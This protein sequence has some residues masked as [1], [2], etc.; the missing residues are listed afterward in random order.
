MAPGPG[1]R[2]AR[3]QA[4]DVLLPHVASQAR[5]LRGREAARQGDLLPHRQRHGL[6]PGR[7]G[8]AR[9]AGPAN[10]RQDRAEAHARRGAL[11]QDQAQEVQLV[12]GRAGQGRPQRPE[13]GLRGGRPHA[14]ARHRR[15]RIQPAVGQGV[16]VTGDGP[17]QQRDSGLVGGR[18]REHGPGRRDDGDARTQARRSGAPAFRPGVAIPA[19]V[20]S[21][22]AR[23][24]RHR[25]EHVAE[26]HLPGQRL[27]GGVL[28]AYEG[29]ILPR[30]EI[31]LVRILQSRARRLHLLLEHAPLSGR[32]K[33][34]DPGAIPRSFDKGR[35]RTLINRPTFGV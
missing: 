3:S 5:P 33:R 13:P 27:H 31:R 14:E 8:P 12:Q 35:L 10:L 34:N 6:P 22:E 16:P 24:P 4:L 2:E 1:A 11:L 18:A 30:Q 20:L 23:L 32:I 9:R 26:G 25:A 21:A 28:R 19:G 15:D 29:R 7:H 17:V